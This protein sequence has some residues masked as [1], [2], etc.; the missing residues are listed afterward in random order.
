MQFCCSLVCC[1]GTART[2]CRCVAAMQH[3]VRLAPRCGVCAPGV[4]TARTGQLRRMFM[5]QRCANMIV[6][7]CAA[8][9]QV[10]GPLPENPLIE[11]GAYTPCCCQLFCFP[12][13][14]MWY[15]QAVAE[16]FGSVVPPRCPSTLRARHRMA[17]VP[18]RGHRAM[19]P[20]V[21]P[22]TGAPREAAAMPSVH[23]TPM[24][25]V[26]RETTGSWRGFEWGSGCYCGSVVFTSWCHGRLRDMLWVSQAIVFAARVPK[27]PLAFPCELHSAEPC[28]CNSMS[29]A[30]CNSTAS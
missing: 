22:T 24:V 20:V 10:T 15:V 30:G 23:Q 3:D 5:L 1:A 6:L 26:P 2:Q 14:V 9:A 12:A 13:A 21:L 25:C 8:A 16:S 27:G 18:R 28:V 17:G 11:Q 4:L 29:T 19:G 7:W